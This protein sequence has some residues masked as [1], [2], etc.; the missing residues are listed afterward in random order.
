MR[1]RG[2]ER[3][4]L[5]RG[6]IFRPPRGPEK[7]SVRME[8]GRPMDGPPEMD[9]PPRHEGRNPPR[10]VG[11]LGDRPPSHGSQDS[12]PDGQESGRP[13]ENLEQ[14]DMGGPGEFEQD[15]PRGE[16]FRPR[17]GEPMDRDEVRQRFLRGENPIRIFPSDHPRNPHNL[18]NEPLGLRLE[19]DKRFR[20]PP[21]QDDH[22]RFPPEGFLDHPNDGPAHFGR[23][24]MPPLEDGEDI[25]IVMPHESDEGGPMP[26]GSLGLGT[27]QEA[28]G[29]S[30][31]QEPMP[32]AEF[33][34]GQ[35]PP[36]RG[37]PGMHR[38]RGSRPFRGR[39]RR[40]FA[41]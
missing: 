16:R 8:G 13:M 18:Q 2:F 3:P 25:R 36:R 31:M 17:P 22:P 38:G 14:Q 11:L 35:G 4:P 39:G 30:G 32:P 7:N 37:R 6:G 29:L 5:R 27:A 9:E 28:L 34:G 26:P 33:H 41:N 20:E 24:R 1:G 21:L 23:R 10:P 19:D 40:P 15:F 12:F